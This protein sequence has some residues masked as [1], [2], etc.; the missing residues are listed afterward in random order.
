VNKSV[1]T[2]VAAVIIAAVMMSGCS[3]QSE[4]AS[5]SKKAHTNSATSYVDA[6]VSECRAWT[7]VNKYG[8]VTLQ[9]GDPRPMDQTFGGDVCK[10]VNVDNLYRATFRPTGRCGNDDLV[11]VRAPP[12]MAK[13]IVTVTPVQQ[14][15]GACSLQAI[16]RH[17][18]VVVFLETDSPDEIRIRY[19]DPGRA[20]RIDYE[21]ASGELH[22]LKQA[23]ARCAEG[24]SSDQFNP[25]ARCLDLARLRSEDNS[26]RDVRT[27]ASIRT[28]GDRYDLAVPFTIDDRRLAIRETYTED[29][30]VIEHGEIPISSR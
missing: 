24:V 21:R 6:A 23:I 26:L 2:L 9:P 12:P 11:D 7:A 27:G 17:P 5:G 20:A 3:E 14:H 19:P 30:M 18:S 4:P 15:T 1:R 10:V 22:I 28:S 13:P 16:V 29:G 25:P 8:P